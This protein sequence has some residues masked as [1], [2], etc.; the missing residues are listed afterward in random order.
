MQ[1]QIET[2]YSQTFFL[3][4]GECNAQGVMPVTLLVSRVI[5]VAT[6]HANRLDIGYGRLSKLSIGWVLSR[7][8]VEMERWPG[9]NETYTMLT[10]IEDFTRFYSD[11]CFLITDA[12]GHVLGHV[13]TVWVAIDMNRRS[14]ADLS[15]IA[16]PEMIFAER[17]CP[18]P[19]QRKMAAVPIDEAVRVADYTFAY[20]DIDFNRHVNSV[21]YIEHILNLWPMEHFDRWTLRTFEITYAHEC[22]FGQR[23][24]IAAIDDTD[25]AAGTATA[26]VDIVRDG[27]RAITAKLTFAS[28]STTSK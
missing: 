17:T 28:N 3:T 21:R 24:T 6:A 20:S 9:I 18:V 12:E 1:P 11:R 4:A 7:V 16:R 14:V 15:D 13:R 27:E 8:S 25:T 26:A 19:K 22:L 5:E 23:V 2:S 10:W